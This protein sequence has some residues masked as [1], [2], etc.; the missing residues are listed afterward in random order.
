MACASAGAFGWFAAVGLQRHKS[1]WNVESLRGGRCRAR[2]GHSRWGMGADNHYDHERRVRN[3]DPFTERYGNGNGYSHGD[4]DPYS[5]ST[6][7]PS[8]QPL[9]VSLPIDT[10]ANTVPIATVIVEPVMTT[11]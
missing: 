1:K 5:Y 2:L 7:T 9:T 6:G 8:P 11:L 3:P 4:S 10:F